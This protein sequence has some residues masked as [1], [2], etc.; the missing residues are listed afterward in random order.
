MNHNDTTAQRPRMRT[1]K[2][3]EKKV[4]YRGVREVKKGDGG[5]GISP[6]KSLCESLRPLRWFFREL[7][8]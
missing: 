5:W 7:P 3:T 2:S 6:K 4:S 1:V 8:Y